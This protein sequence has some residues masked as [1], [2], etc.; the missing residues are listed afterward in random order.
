VPFELIVVELGKGEHKSPAYLE[1]QPFGQIPVLDD[2]GF[3]VFESRAI[4]RY[5]A[6]KYADQGTKLIPTDSDLKARALFEQAASIEQSNFEAFAGPAVYENL[7]KKWTGEDPDPVVFDALIQK[8]DAKLEGYDKILSKQKYLAGNELTLADLFH[9]PHGSLL[10]VAGS[11]VLERKPN[12]SRVREGRSEP[13]T[14]QGREPHAE[15]DLNCHKIE[16]SGVPNFIQ[17]LHEDSQTSRTTTDKPNI[18][19]KENEEEDEAWCERM[20]ERAEVG[21]LQARR[22]DMKRNRRAEEEAKKNQIPQQ[23]KGKETRSSDGYATAMTIRTTPERIRVKEEEEEGKWGNEDEKLR[24]R[25]RGS[26]A[27]SSQQNKS[28]AGN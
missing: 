3:L 14:S 7:F 13:G 19:D 1:K 20:E 24:R 9:L 12:V 8:L 26:E 21:G 15:S 27:I 17:A 4:C 28:Q 16:E 11:N 22:P 25:G 10:A 5:I 6:T 18:D 2:D 23:P